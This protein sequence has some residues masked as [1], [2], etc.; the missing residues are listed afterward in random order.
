[1]DQ[2]TNNTKINHDNLNILFISIIKNNNYRYCN[3]SNGK[4]FD[5]CLLAKITLLAMH[6]C[7]S[8]CK[9]YSA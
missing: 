8:L 5:W 4:K 3:L 2:M 9:G 7:L 1:M 6:G